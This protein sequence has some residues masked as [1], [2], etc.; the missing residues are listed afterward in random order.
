MYP[1]VINELLSTFS[2]KRM[3]RGQ[4]D[5]AGHADG[6]QAVSSGVGWDLL[7]AGGQRVVHRQ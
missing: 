2:C 3:A 5:R 4:A 6:A 7:L 1:D